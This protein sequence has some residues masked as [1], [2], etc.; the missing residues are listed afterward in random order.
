MRQ[1]FYVVQAGTGADGGNDKEK[2]VGVSLQLQKEDPTLA[3][4][5]F[6]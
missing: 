1:L 5:D 4:T 6:P 2:Q 3:T